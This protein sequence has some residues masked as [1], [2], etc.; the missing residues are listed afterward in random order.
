MPKHS[1]KHNQES[2]Q[3][4]LLSTKGTKSL[5][6]KRF[7]RIAPFPHWIVQMVNITLLLGKSEGWLY[8]LTPYRLSQFFH[9]TFFQSVQTQNPGLAM[10]SSVKPC[11]F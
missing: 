10:S 6:E 11:T 3:I 5:S 9:Q 1:L 8:D 4:V 7:S 2:F